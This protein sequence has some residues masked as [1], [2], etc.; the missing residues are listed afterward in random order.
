MQTNDTP[1]K[2]LKFP[3]TNNPALAAFG[4]SALDS[5]NSKSPKAQTITVC[6]AC[7]SAACWDGEAYCENYRTAGTK[8]IPATPEPLP[9]PTPKALEIYHCQKH[10][11]SGGEA[12]GMTVSAKPCAVCGTV[13]TKPDTKAQSVPELLDQIDKDIFDCCDALQNAYGTLKYRG[14]FSTAEAAVKAEEYLREWPPVWMRDD[15][16]VLDQV[17]AKIGTDKIRQLFLSQE[18]ELT[19]LRGEN[20]NLKTAVKHTYDFCLCKRFRTKGFNY[21]ET[22]PRMGKAGVGERW[23]TPCDICAAVLSPSPRE[24]H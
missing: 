24:N 10:H 5:I 3:D 2:A 4:L 19:R 14:Q 1:P 11:S 6:D 9:G 13:G 21:G 12:W 17:P 8:E 15:T 16:F 23:M 18:A 7:E 20:E 22:H